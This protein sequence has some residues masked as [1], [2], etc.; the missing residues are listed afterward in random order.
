MTEKVRAG[1]QNQ[2]HGEE[3]SGLLVAPY[4]LTLFRQDLEGTPPAT[5]LNTENHG[6]EPSPWR[7]HCSPLPNY[8]D[9]PPCPGPFCSK[10]PPPQPWGT[11][12][13]MLFTSSCLMAR[14]LFTGSPW[15]STRFQITLDFFFY[16]ITQGVVVCLSPPPPKKRHS[17]K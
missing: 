1:F 16:F 11:Q 3:S 10:V 8:G 5:D 15:C 2:G 12:H 13:S 7:R 9:L 14:D 17:G 4:L 6:N